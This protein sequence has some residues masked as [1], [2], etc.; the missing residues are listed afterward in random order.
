V[1]TIKRE[2][3]EISIILPCR[4]E[5]KAVA[6]C[7]NNAKNALKKYGIDGEIIVSDSSSDRSPVIAKELGA[8]VVKHDKKGYGIAYL[9]GF[10]AARGK[11]IFCADCDG[12]Y[13]FNEIPRF[14]SYLRQGYDFVNGNRFRGKMDRGA[15]PF[16]HKYIGNPAL[17]FILRVFFR[18]KLK[19][20]HC[21]MRAI[22][23]EA[24]DKLDLQTTGMEFASEMIIK[25]A[26]N[27]LKTKDVPINYHK[28]I[29]KSKLRSFSDGWRHLR[30]ML[31]Y[32]PDY[33]FMIPGGFFLLLGILIM[34]LFLKGPITIGEITFYTHPMIVGSFLTILGYQIITL[35]VYAKTYSVSIG[36]EKKDRLVE[37]LAK[38][39]NFES[40][41]AFGFLLILISIVFGF[42][43]LFNWI[44]AENK[45][46]FK[47]NE[48]IFILTLAI[49][50]IQT[51]FSAFFLSILLVEKKK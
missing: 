18:S 14:L 6:F 51:M 38:K 43:I 7:V 47:T 42:V 46:L 29:G 1:A 37:F 20:A 26:K 23:R 2:N 35:G 11:Y 36:F 41:M 12:T 3:P 31:M 45:G 19:D 13:D 39:L 10:K 22:T 8:T 34:I 44:T 48:M 9:E 5:E 27:N 30:F 33:L 16:S 32:A 49:S 21:G 15:M 40:G 28:R 50:G 17:S 25:A 4:N 24:L